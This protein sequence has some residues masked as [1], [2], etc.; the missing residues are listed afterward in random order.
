[1]RV[2][3]RK[4]EEV[5]RYGHWINELLRR[6]STR[7][8]AEVLD[9][10]LR[11]IDVAE[12][13]GF[14][15]EY[16]EVPLMGLRSIFGALRGVS[17]EGALVRRVRDRSIGQSEWI[18][19]SLPRLFRAVSGN[20][21]P[22]GLAAIREWLDS[23]DVD[24]ELAAV[25]LLRES[26][27]RFL[28]THLDLVAHAIERAEA[29]GDD[30]ATRISNRFHSA[31][32]SRGRSGVA[33]QPFPQ[34]VTLRDDATTAMSRTQRGTRLYRLLASL[35]RYA[36]TAIQEQIISEEELQG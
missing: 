12:L 32:T 11:R 19:A 3:L 16:Q 1:M 26:G 34:D 36:E 33:G 25:D 5:G 24:R 23:R 14:R 8:P 22:E 18:P 30:F 4:L 15:A 21:G 13:R 31:A 9:L 10:F 29:I 28:F 2:I 17:Q 35:R 7:M 20:Y 6:L 27:P